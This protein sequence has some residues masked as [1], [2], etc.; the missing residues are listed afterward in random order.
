M[1]APRAAVD[2]ALIRAS[3]PIEEVV[4]AA[5][6]ELRRSARGWLARC[7]FHDDNVPSMSV[8][9]VPDRFRCFGC[10]VGGDVIEFV[11]RL[12][13]VPFI[14]A[15]H[16]LEAGALDPQTQRAAHSARRPMRAVPDLGPDVPQWR[17]HEINALAWVQYGAPVATASAHGY[18][19]RRRGIDL[20]AVTSLHPGWPI[21]GFAGSGWTT[22]VDHLR[23]NGV[24]DDEMLATDLGA[25]SGHGGLHDTLRDRLILPVTRPDG[26]I[27]A[28]IGRDLSGRPHAPKYRNPTRTATYDKSTF[29]YHPVPPE[30][31]PDGTLIV[32]EGVLDALAI[33]SAAASSG[34][35][36]R[37][38]ACT[39]SG[40]SVSA[41]Q[42]QLVLT[43]SPG[44]PV[45][46]LDGDSAGSRATLRW[47]EAICL[48]GRRPALVTRLPDGLDPAEW[49]HRLGPAGLH[50]FDPHRALSADATHPLIPGRALATL[51]LHRHPNDPVRVA[52]DLAQIAYQ[53][54]RELATSLLSQATAEMTRQGWNSGDAFKRALDTPP[55]ACE[56]A[57]DQGSQPPP[58]VFRPQLRSVA[59]AQGPQPH[60]LS[61]PSLT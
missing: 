60:P 38:A 17:V 11:R 6:V 41:D 3:N 43:A 35:A 32:V 19:S 46:A 8:A 1:S 48:D 59:A 26:R 24:T 4:A 34:Q 16:L 15:V 53:L 12:H 28:F 45:I 61:G 22:L 25:V 5:G 54:P 39:T 30:L 23:R 9:G 20:D 27:D 42:V 44:S 33:T 2:V 31:H 58:A 50:A 14:E 29:L 13:N 52:S 40:L 21:A 49:L 56:P 51:C 10:G 37:F 55:H 18:L 57:S 47:L 36:H 7:P